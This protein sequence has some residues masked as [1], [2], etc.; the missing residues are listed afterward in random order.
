LVNYYLAK[1]ILCVACFLRAFRPTNFAARVIGRRGTCI[2]FVGLDFIQKEQGF[3]V[4]S[5]FLHGI[6]FKRDRWKM[7]Q[8]AL[9]A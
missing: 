2:D 6:S 4:E 1:I 5:K 9:L 8:G 7:R 3:F